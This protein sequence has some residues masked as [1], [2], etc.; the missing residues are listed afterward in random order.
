LAKLAL[1]THVHLLGFSVLYGLTGLSFA[2]SAYPL[3]MRIILAPAPLL[4]QVVDISFWWLARL[5]A[6][7]GPLFA[8]GIMGTGGLVA[9]SLGAQIVLGMLGLFQG[10]A[11]LA[12]LG[13]FAIGGLFGLALLG[14]VVL[15]HLKHEKES[16]SPDPLAITGKP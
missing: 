13:V 9:L 16:S 14:F 12:M 15:P 1:S 8:Q 5:D 4:L 6:P 11:R 2:L 10:R 7:L 3:W